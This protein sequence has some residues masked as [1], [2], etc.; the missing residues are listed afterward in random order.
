MRP[1]AGIRSGGLADGKRT[2]LG[3]LGVTQSLS[4]ERLWR[5]AAGRPRCWFVAIE[6]SSRHGLSEPL[7]RALAARGVTGR[8]RAE[9]YLNP[10]AEGACSTDP[11]TFTDMDR[12]AG[13]PGGRPG[14]QAAGWWSSPTMTWTAQPPPLPSWCAGSGRW[15]MTCRSMSPTAFWRA[16]GH[17]RP[18][19]KR[20]EEPKA[21]SWWSPWTAG[22]RR[23]T[24][25]LRG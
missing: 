18:P 1:S 2:V 22:P 12:A 23:S 14:A 15:A 10:D 6:A 7:A 19:F 4:G 9:T 13:D 20:P 8:G 5:R 16:M 24:P 21:P 25:G 3:Y 11:S 17:R